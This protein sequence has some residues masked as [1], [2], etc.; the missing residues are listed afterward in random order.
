MRDGFKSA[1]EMEFEEQTTFRYREYVHRFLPRLSFIQTFSGFF[2]RSQ[3]TGAWVMAG[4]QP[5]AYPLVTPAPSGP[6]SAEELASARE[7]QA[8]CQKLGAELL[9]ISVP[10][11]SSDPGRTL[12]LAHLLNVPA[13][14][15]GLDTRKLTTFDLSHLSE[16]SAA[17]YTRAFIH[18]VAPIF[19]ST[20]EKARH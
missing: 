6:P 9:L 12:A 5:G 13:L 14:V 10:S 4:S 17:I 19:S 16:K 7:F 15:P 3:S 20:A 2:F 1:W 8:E 11:P 18:S